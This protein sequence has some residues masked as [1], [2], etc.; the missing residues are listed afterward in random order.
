M[1][2]HNITFLW[3]TDENY[4]L[5]II[6]YPPYQFFCYQMIAVLCVHAASVPFLVRF[7]LGKDLALFPMGK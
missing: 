2:T 1:S 3:R 6:K 4:P 5:I 7:D